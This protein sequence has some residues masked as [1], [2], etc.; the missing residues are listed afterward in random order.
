[1]ALPFKL[2]PEPPKQ[3]AEADPFLEFDSERPGVRPKMPIHEPLFRPDLPEVRSERLDFPLSDATLGLGQ[4]RRT[5][6]ISPAFAFGIGVAGLVAA[7]VAY[8]QLSQVLSTRATASQAQASTTE[9]P[10]AATAPVKT[11][12][13]TSTSRSASPAPSPVAAKSAAPVAPAGTGRIDVASTPPGALV[14]H[15][16]VARGLTPFILTGLPAGRHTVVVSRG[17][18]RAART[19]E[20]GPGGAT[21]VSI[22]IPYSVVRSSPTPRVPGQIATAEVDAVAPGAAGWLTFEL[23]ID[24]LVYQDGRLRGNTR[25]GRVTLPAG[26]HNLVLANP[27]YEYREVV[28][29]TVTAGSAAPANVVLPNGYLSLNALP[30]ADVW[31]DGNSVGTTPL[32]NLS[33]PI[34]SHEVLW[35]HP[36]LGERRQLVIVKAKTPAR[37]GVDF[38]R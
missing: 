15:N 20:L 34:G 17:S 26:T 4:P 11:S 30:W 12:L 23:P 29:V 16:G 5:S 38:T 7:A 13:A 1:M 22:A 27:A 21:A 14:S 3:P 33:L 6:A 28:S 10:P 31:V 8:Y 2:N 37:A 25:D 9:T 18:F 35:K 24:V 32:A 19:V 36:T